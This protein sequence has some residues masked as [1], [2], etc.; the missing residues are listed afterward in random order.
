M[1]DTARENC[2]STLLSICS[3]FRIPHIVSQSEHSDVAE[4][5]HSN[6]VQPFSFNCQVQQ[7]VQHLEEHHEQCKPYNQR[8]RGIPRGLK[9]LLRCRQR[10]SVRCS[11]SPVEMELTLLA[12][13]V[14][15]RVSRTSDECPRSSLT[16]SKIRHQ[17]TRSDP[18]LQN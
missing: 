13:V 3:E 9:D 6:L 8:Q 2:F 12:V 16:D 4:V 15:S 17:T 5:I 18:R 10:R 11:F 14:T 7:E 1:L